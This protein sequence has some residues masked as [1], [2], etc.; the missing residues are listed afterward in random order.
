MRVPFLA[1]AV[2]ATL[3][4]AHTPPGP[5]RGQSGLGLERFTYRASPLA[6]PA[7]GDD[8]LQKLRKERYSAATSELNARLEAFAA[9]TVTGTLDV[10]TDCLTRQVLPAELALTD[11]GA[12]HVATLERATA[13]AAYVE[14]V[15]RTR[16]DSGR[17]PVQ[18]F[19]HTRFVH[20]DLQVRLLEGKK[21]AAK[22]GLRVK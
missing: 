20:L 7:A 16:Y 3:T 18:D 14:K 13:A 22:A 11:Q 1:M 12:D 21:T 8:E 17:I 2:V 4:L 6:V 15:N 9:G 10:L 19:D 5:V